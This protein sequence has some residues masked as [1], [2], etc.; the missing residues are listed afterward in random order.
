MVAGSLYALWDHQRVAQIF[1]P[2]PGAGPLAERIERG[3]RSL[4]FGHHADYA[5]ATA[6]P[7]GQPL[8]VFDR[9]LHQLVDVRLLQAYAEALHAAGHYRE[10]LYAAQRLREFRRPDAQ[11][12][13]AECETAD[14]PAWQCER[15]P[16]QGLDWRALA[17]AAK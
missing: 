13:F 11:A 16:V 14:P 17:R 15:A 7:D 4:L 6:E 9:P 2:D 8:S 1:A 5:A 3:Q 12:W 10:A